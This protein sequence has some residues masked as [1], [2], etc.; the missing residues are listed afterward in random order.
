MVLNGNRNDNG[1]LLKQINKLVDITSSYDSEKIKE[2]LKEIV[3]E[4]EPLPPE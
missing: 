1:K 4:Y 3:P 2:K